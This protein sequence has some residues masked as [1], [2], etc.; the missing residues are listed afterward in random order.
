MEEV[1]QEGGLV[2][3][4]AGL[5]S[6]GFSGAQLKRLLLPGLIAS[7]GLHAYRPLAIVSDFTKPLEIDQNVLFF[8]EV[9]LF[10]FLLSSSSRT[11]FYIYE[12]FR[13]PWITWPA[14]LWTAR[15]VLRRQSRLE[16]L[17]EKGMQGSAEAERIQSYL[18][19]FPYRADG[20]DFVYEA[21]RPTRIGN[22]IASYE[23]YPENV[24]G[25]DAV[26]YWNHLTFLAPKELRE[27]LDDKSSLAESV[28]LS[29]GAGAVIAIV[30]FLVLLYKTLKFSYLK[31]NF[32]LPP[33]GKTLALHTF[34][35]G[36]VAFLVFY[37]LSF[38]AYREYRDSFRAMIDL[39]IPEFETW[40]SKAPVAPPAELKEDARKVEEYL[41]TL[42]PHRKSTKRKKH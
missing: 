36:V 26:F 2:A 6:A 28:L 33:E 23:L 31:G 18:A 27:D 12:G 13:L 3:E 25:I 39:A 29:S 19:D 40:L 14:K 10:G 38:P 4:S 21:E 7:I 32:F 1:Q 20:A 16:D 9:I 41:R 34:L 24:Y 15:K 22:I 37:R 17:F 42:A 11:I 30:S 5:S 8:I 35:F